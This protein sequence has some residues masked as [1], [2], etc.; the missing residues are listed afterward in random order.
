MPKPP[1]V[2]HL[3]S[4]CKRI[5][6]IIKAGK[7]VGEFPLSQTSLTVKDWDLPGAS[8]GICI[9]CD[10][11]ERAQL[12]RMKAARAKGKVIENPPVWAA[13]KA[14]WRRAVSIVRRSYGV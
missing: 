5:V 14:K 13:D 3:C 6:S 2:W 8:H 7:N 9:K 1:K 10:E 12:K 11:L 4:Y